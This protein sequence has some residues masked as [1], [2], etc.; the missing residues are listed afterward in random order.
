M[1][2]QTLKAQA[3]AD[4]SVRLASCSLAGASQRVVEDSRA[5]GAKFGG[6]QY[7][8]AKAAGC[9]LLLLHFEEVKVWTDKPVFLSVHRTAKPHLT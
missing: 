5:E 3:P 4:A 6:G 7:S 8:F 9:D 1:G 2:Q